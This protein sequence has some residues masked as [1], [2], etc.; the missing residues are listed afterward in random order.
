MKKSFSIKFLQDICLLLWFS[1]GEELNFSFTSA[2]KAGKLPATTV[3]PLGKFLFGNSVRV[4]T[5]IEATSKGGRLKGTASNIERE[6]DE[7]ASLVLVKGLLNGLGNAVSKHLEV[8]GEVGLSLGLG[9][10][11][12]RLHTLCVTPAN[13]PNSSRTR[14][15]LEIESLELLYESLGT[16]DIPICLEHLNLILFLSKVMMRGGGNSYHS[17]GCEQD[18]LE[19]YFITL[20]I[21]L[22]YRHLYTSI[23][24]KNEKIVHPLNLPSVALG[25]QL[26]QAAEGGQ[27]DPESRPPP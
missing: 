12:A 3:D 26:L 21:I 10:G 13:G 16:C 15:C 7:G 17:G 22:I 9:D 20:I 24:F 25:G 8:I 6:T 19:H 4:F 18:F 27:A 23:I 2:N 5:S 1:R 11:H 14:V